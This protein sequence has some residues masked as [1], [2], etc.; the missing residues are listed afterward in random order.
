MFSAVLWITLLS[1]AE[2]LLCAL[3]CCP[4]AAWPLATAISNHHNAHRARVASQRSPWKASRV[5]W[6]GSPILVLQPVQAIHSLVQD[7]VRRET[8]PRPPIEVI[9]NILVPLSEIVADGTISSPPLLTS[10]PLLQNPSRPL[11]ACVLYTKRA[12]HCAEQSLSISTSEPLVASL[13]KGLI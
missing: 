3:L 12:S 10:S 13:S 5:C 6:G 4:F 11:P 2:A 1:P 8:E 9:E 7:D